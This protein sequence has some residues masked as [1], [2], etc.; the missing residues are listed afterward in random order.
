MASVEKE[1]KKL[2]DPQSNLVTISTQ[3]PANF[4]TYISKIHLKKYEV[5][6]LRALGNAAEIS[7]QVAENLQRHGLAE[8]G[9]IW[10]ETIDIE[11]N[12]GRTVKAIRFTIHLKRSQ[13]FDKLIGDTLK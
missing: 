13:N 8:I 4:F 7:V 6:E 3:K 2:L 12:E 9:K 10:S 11:N 5:I 1:E